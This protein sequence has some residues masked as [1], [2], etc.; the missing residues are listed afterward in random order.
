MLRIDSTEQFVKKLFLAKTSRLVVGKTDFGGLPWGEYIGEL[1]FVKDDNC[2]PHHARPTLSLS[3]TS[4]ARS[5]VSDPLQFG[6]KVLVVSFG[7][8]PQEVKEVCKQANI[9]TKVAPMPN[10][11]KI[12]PPF[13]L[14]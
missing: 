14:P 12:L 7:G 4:L 8:V 10:R 2:G 5:L 1:R 13:L 9:H 6:A 11:V 3:L